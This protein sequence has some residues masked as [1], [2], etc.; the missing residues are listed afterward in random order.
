MMKSSRLEIVQA[1]TPIV[2]CPVSGFGVTAVS[3]GAIARVQTP[4]QVKDIALGTI[5]ALSVLGGAG[6]GLAQSSPRQA[7]K[8]EA[9]TSQTRVG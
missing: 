3:I 4:E 5:G 1:C 6:A 9:E 8:A 2:F 7:E